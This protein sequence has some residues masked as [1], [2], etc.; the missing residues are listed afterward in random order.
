MSPKEVIDGA[1][2]TYEETLCRSLDIGSLIARNEVAHKWIVTFGVYVIRETSCWRFVDIAKQAHMLG[3]A[4]SIAGARI[5]TRAAI[6][7]LSTLVYSISKMEEVVSGKISFEEF[8]EC[9][10]RVYMGSRIDKEL[11]E[12]INV[13]TMVK[14]MEKKHQGILDIFEDLCE[15]AHP[16]MIGLTDGYT[17]INREEYVTAFGNFWLEKYGHQHEQ[18]L[19][20]CMEIFEKEY[21][22]EWIEKFHALEKWL[23]ENDSDLEKR[24]KEKKDAGLKKK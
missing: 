18:A 20:I 21:N 24:R 6:E 5:L 13:L 19:L 15:T 16:S 11:P 2:K 12:T 7:T 3:E 10:N 14:N 8:C 4:N 23:V 9:I 22:E 17:K 1:I